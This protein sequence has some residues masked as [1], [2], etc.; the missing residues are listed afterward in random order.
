[1][2]YA[3]S[4]NGFV[5]GTGQR[6]GAS[7]ASLSGWRVN[8]ASIEVTPGAFVN[9][10]GTPK[11]SPGDPRLGLNLH[12]DTPEQ[13]DD[14][15]DLA[16]KA[17]VPSAVPLPLTIGGRS[18]WVQ[19]LNAVP[20]TAPEWPG[21]EKTT[22][23]AVAFVAAD[24]VLY[25]ATQ[26]TETVDV[27]SPVSTHSFEV[28]NEGVLVKRAPRGWEW[29]L[30]AHGTTTNPRIRVDHADGT[31][32]EILFSGL[33]I[34]NTHVLTIGADLV[35]RVQSAIVSGRIRSTTEAGGP[36]RAPRWW[37]L[38]PSNGSDGANEV[39]VTVASGAFSGYC[40]TRSTWD[41]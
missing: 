31:F 38:H 41:A 17:F 25:S 9:A 12:A 36:G 16:M 8:A 18:K 21:A 20:Q 34:P 28:A 30:R 24:P 37:R 33:T 15:I 5:F 39:T 7:V 27:G 23:M 26:E 11:L 3:G 14:L 6:P 40:K 1:M 32:E 2:T 19:V 29:R 13:L 22:S 10:A 35:P 4:Y